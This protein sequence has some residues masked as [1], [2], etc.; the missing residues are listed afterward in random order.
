MDTRVAIV[1]LN[2]LTTKEPKDLIHTI[3]IFLPSTRV[4]LID[5][6]SPERVKK[7]LK[8]ISLNND[9]LSVHFT[10]KNLGFAQGNNVGIQLARKEGY[11]YI[12]CSNSDI[13][14]RNENILETLVS[15]AQSNLASVIGPNIIDLNKMNQNPYMKNRPDSEKAL[16]LYKVNSSLPRIVLS[17]LPDILKKKLKQVLDLKSLKNLKQTKCRSNN[18]GYVYSLHGAFLMFTPLFFHHY[19]GF[20]PNTF[21]YGEELV[22]GE[23]LYRKGLKAYYESSVSVT[24]LEDR[25]SSLIW[26]SQSQIKPRLYARSSYRY[27]Y[28]NWYSKNL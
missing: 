21:L 18:S 4:F 9:N 7:E 3:S 19:K 11:E 6:G 28:Q 13:L 5:N 17:Q 1:I 10:N 22:L 8:N 25:T 24:H 16:L 2:Y 23:M 20:D 15:S 27:W 26:N 12:V 14:I